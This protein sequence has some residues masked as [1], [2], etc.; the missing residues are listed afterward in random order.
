[1][2]GKMTT[3]ITELVTLTPV[4]GVLYRLKQFLTALAVILA[5]YVT[6]IVMPVYVANYRFEDAI[7]NAAR[8]SAYNDDEEYQIHDEVMLKA[9]E[10]GVPLKEENLVVTREEKL[11]RIQATYDV[12]I[13][14]P[15]GRLLTLSFY[16]S[17]V[18]K[19][20]SHEAIQ[21]RKAKEGK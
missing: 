14:L 9:K 15:T 8:I 10:I 5:V 4:G 3:R 1:M 13:K 12:P 20:L 7:Q 19:A 2:P 17:S 21:A 16:P 11:V 18:E 6:W